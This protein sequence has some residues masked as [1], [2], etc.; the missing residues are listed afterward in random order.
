[1]IDLLF[2]AVDKFQRFFLLISKHN[3]YSHMYEYINM[4]I[5]YI[6]NETSYLYLLIDKTNPCNL[7]VMAYNKLIFNVK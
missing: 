6:Y 7:Q 4:E 1:M 3:I 5:I 2:L